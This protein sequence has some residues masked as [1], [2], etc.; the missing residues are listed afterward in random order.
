LLASFGQDLCLDEDCNENINSCS[1]VGFLYE[2]PNGIQYD[3]LASESYM[4]GTEF[5]FSVV[6]IEVF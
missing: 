1:N 6:E 5:N 3:S 2:P 4:A